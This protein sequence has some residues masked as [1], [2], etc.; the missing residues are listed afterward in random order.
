LPHCLD[1]VGAESGSPDMVDGIG[2]AGW[3]D[4]L[5]LALRMVRAVQVALRMAKGCLETRMKVPVAQ[6]TR[7]LDLDLDH[8]RDTADQGR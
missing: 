3:W 1:E 2:V 8:H 6:G 5:V 7:D 4:G